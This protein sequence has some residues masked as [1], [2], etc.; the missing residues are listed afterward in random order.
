[1]H[2]RFALYAIAAGAL[3]G[4]TAMSAAQQTITIRAG[5]VIDGK[6]GVQ[7]NAVIAIEGSRIAR[8]GDAGDLVKIGSELFTAA[9]PEFV[10]R[11]L[12]GGREVFLDL[13]WH[14]IP[15]TV[16]RAAASAAS[17]GVR[18]VTVHA[19]GGAAM[20][21][22]AVA[23][24]GAECGVLAV[25][26]L[27]SLDNAS[28]G[29]AWGRPV[30]IE[31]EVLRLAALAHGA[32]VHG[33]VCSGEEAGAVHARF[34]DSLRLLVPGIRLPGGASHDQVRGITPRAAADAGASYLVVGRAVTAAPDPVAALAAVQ[35]SL[36]EREG[37]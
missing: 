20:L 27:T 26:V 16:R 4:M 35:A 37:S 2:T 34:S 29:E 1:M 30:S 8:L 23:G 14:D 17:L 18:L 36:G 33:I 24:A 32:A 10:H 6:G 22:A 19:T 21:E 3:V 9:G 25:T 31:E 28:L 7:R 12:A 15:T 11:V 5:T 13:K